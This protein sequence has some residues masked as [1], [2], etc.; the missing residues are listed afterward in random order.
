MAISEAVDQIRVSPEPN[1]RRYSPRHSTPQSVSFVRRRSSPTAPSAPP[2]AMP[3]HALLPP[4]L[5]LALLLAAVAACFVPLATVAGTPLAGPE[6]ESEF[7]RLCKF[8]D[9]LRDSIPEQIDAATGAPIRIGAYQIRQASSPI[10]PIRPLLFRTHF[11]LLASP[12]APCFLV[13]PASLLFPSR[14]FL[15]PLRH[16]PPPPTGC[17]SCTAI[18]RQ[19]SLT[20]RHGGEQP[21][22]SDGH[23]EAWFTQYSEVGR[24]FRTRLYHYPNHQLPT[25]LWYHDHAI[26]IT[27]LNIAA[28]L[29]GFFVLTDP[30]GVE[31]TLGWLPQ[32]EFC[33]PLALSDRRFF[34]NGSIDYPRQGVLPR[35]HPHWVPEYLGDK[36]LVTGKVW[37]YLKVRRALYR[38][39]VLG[40]AN[41]R[42]FNLRFICATPRNYPHFTPPFSGNKLPIIVVRAS[43][44]EFLLFPT[45]T[46]CLSAPLYQ[47]VPT[48]APHESPLPLYYPDFIPPF[49]CVACVLDSD[50]PQL[51][52]THFP[53]T[54][55]HHS[56]NP[57]IPS[58]PSLCTCPPVHSPAPPPSTHQ[59]GSD[60]GYLPR[61]AVRTSLLVAPAQRYDILIN[62]SSPCNLH[63]PLPFRSERYDI[64]VDFSSLRSSCADVILT[65]DAPAPF[66]AGE[67]VTNDT[68]VVMRFIVDHHSPRLPAPR[69]P[70]SLVCTPCLILSPYLSLPRPISPCV[71]QPVPPVD[72]S[73]VV[74]ERWITAVEETDPATGQSIRL[75]LGDLPY[76]A[77]PTETPRENS[78]ELWHLINLTPDAHPIHL[79][80]IQHRPLWRRPFDLAAYSNG[81]CSFTNAALPSC[82][83]GAQ[84]PVAAYERGWK[85]TTIL[86]PAT[87]LTLWTP[88]YSQDGT[89][90]PFDATR[91]PGYVW[92]CHIVEHED[93]SMMR[94]LI[95]TK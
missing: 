78:E 50:L 59:I 81:T 38:F 4:R 94:P 14:P 77:P 36:I 1:R 92:H 95:I 62:F 65:N 9:D 47:P 45:T 48:P 33:V 80:L 5:R 84:Q 22:F 35:V 2:R 58:T 44:C 27:R 53:S 19:R 70:K 17:R 16:L 86:P 63:P 20:H 23:P 28:G 8:V 34:A 67:P 57:Q 46:P 72:T 12:S 41:T 26:A 6:C 91:G 76:S 93:N 60:G 32:G 42:F 3:R 74:V 51:L 39:R 18:C 61:P 7:P 83:T 68:A 11:R 90:F 15:T 43:H 89:P 31:R 79:H 73:R 37:P 10:P 30:R 49:T 13:F 56:T 87:V 40:A 24:A 82:F 66:P 85:D 55:P 54:T 21:S 88:W 64:L 29:T 75:L 52:C 71:L 69:I 25:T